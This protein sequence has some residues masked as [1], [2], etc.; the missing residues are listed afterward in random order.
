M[1]GK[2]SWD[3]LAKQMEFWKAKSYN[4]VVGH[5]LYLVIPLFQK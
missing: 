3:V 4:D 1:D 2:Q 5:S